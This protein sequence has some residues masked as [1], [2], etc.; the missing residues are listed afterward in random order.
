MIWQRG[1]FVIVGFLQQVLYKTLYFF[2]NINLYNKL[3]KKE[4]INN[5]ESLPLIN[6]RK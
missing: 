5:G 4:L 1:I 6:E 2:Y 3:K